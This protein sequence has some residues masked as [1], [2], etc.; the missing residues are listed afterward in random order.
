MTSVPGDNLDLIRRIL[1][2]GYLELKL[3]RLATEEVPEVAAKVTVEVTENGAATTIEGD[4]VGPIDALWGCLIQRYS[5]EY[6]SLKS[7]ELAGFSVQAQIE[8]KRRRA[9][10]DALGTVEVA[11]TNS[12]GRRFTFKDASRSVTASAARAVIAVAEYFVNAERA[13]VTLS[14]ARKDAVARGRQDLV[15]RYT[16]ELAEVV[17]STSYAEVIESLRRE[18]GSS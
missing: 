7:I 11:V 1:G 18:L 16:A 17:K 12:E 8:S 6:Q 15:A 14:H 5:R 9:G 13:F 2:S 4:G 10:L 3:A